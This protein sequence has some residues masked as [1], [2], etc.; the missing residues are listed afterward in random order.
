MKFLFLYCTSLIIS[1]LGYVYS[2]EVVDITNDITE[3]CLKIENKLNF[4]QSYEWFHLPPKKRTELLDDNVYACHI[5]NSMRTNK[6]R[7]GMLNFSNE[8]IKKE[9]SDAPWTTFIKKSTYSKELKKKRSITTEINYRYPQDIRINYAQY[10]NNKVEQGSAPIEGPMALLTYLSKIQTMQLSIKGSIGEIGVHHGRFFVGLAHLAM[11][12]ESLWACDVFEDQ[13][14]NIDKSGKGSYELF[15]QAIMTNGI[16][17]NDVQ[18]IKGSSSDLNSVLVNNSLPTFRIFSVDGGHTRQ[19][20]HNDLLLAAIN[21]TPG[22]IIVIDDFPNFSWWGVLEGTF[23]TLN[24]IPF[25]LAPICIGYNKLYLTT[26]EYHD[27]YCN[28]LINH[29]EIS[30]T[31]VSRQVLNGWK[32][33]HLEWNTQVIS[34]LKDV[35]IRE[36]KN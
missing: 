33:L 7:K 21:L 2:D 25:T 15:K 10:G 24:N 32:F 4:I 23:T 27:L 18:I 13:Q 16:E 17:E 5:I 20:T 28:A 8:M 26:P 34:L 19:L 36:I 31:I 29:H 12:N 6:L 35:W 22:G 14:L 9:F 1:I 30:S 3:L 11:N